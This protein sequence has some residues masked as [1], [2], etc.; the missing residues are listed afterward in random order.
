MNVSGLEWGITLAVTIG[1]LLVDVLIFGRRP[2]EPSRRETGTALTVYIGLA[3]AFGLW[4]W[5]YHGSQFG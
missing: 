4:T 5:F 1:I 3:V 2:H